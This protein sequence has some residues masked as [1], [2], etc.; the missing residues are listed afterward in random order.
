VGTRID[1]VR[2]RILQRTPWSQENLQDQK[3]WVGI[4]TPVTCFPFRVAKSKAF[5]RR[6]ILKY[7]EMDSFQI[8]TSI[9]LYLR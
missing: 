3:M 1:A 2:N 9:I 6:F 4:E 8:E 7:C 5:S